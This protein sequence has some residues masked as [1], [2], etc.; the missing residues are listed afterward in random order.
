MKQI[1]FFFALVSVVALTA[2]STV[3]SRISQ[4]RAS[5]ETWPPAVQQKVGAGQV[6]VGFTTE[7]IR[8]ALGDPD[9]SWTRTTAQGT[10]EVWSY[11]D[12][13]PHFGFGL[14][15]GSMHGSTA[16]GTG[17]SV[18]NARFVGEKTR[19]I[20]DASGRVAALEEVSR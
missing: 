14:G 8:V 18:G 12:R 9:W 16:V 19:V 7:Q 13:G 4:H 5:Y 17:V 3:G 20:F 6:D 11:R 1:T 15:F 10:S 2:C